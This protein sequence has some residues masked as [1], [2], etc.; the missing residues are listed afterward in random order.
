MLRFNPVDL[1]PASR[2]TGDWAQLRTRMMPEVDSPAED[3]DVPPLAHLS[4]SPTSNADNDRDSCISHSSPSGSPSS[5]VDLSHN[6][7]QQQPQQPHQHPPA[8]PFAAPLP[9][10]LSPSVAN[11]RPSGSVATTVADAS[12]ML[13]MINQLPVPP[14]S[15][16]MVH[17]HRQHYPTTNHLHHQH[18]HH[19]HLHYNTNTQLTTHHQPT[20][21][22]RHHPYATIGDATHE[23]L[24]RVPVTTGHITVQ[25]QSLHCEPAAAAADAL[26]CAQPDGTAVGQ[27]LSWHPHV[28]AK[29]PRSP[30]PHSIVDILGGDRSAQATATAAAMSDARATDATDATDDRP[31]HQQDCA[32]GSINAILNAS[33]VHAKKTR[34]EREF[35]R[36]YGHQPSDGLL[37]ALSPGPPLLGN[38]QPLNLCIAK[39]PDRHT[40]AE[41]PPPTALRKGEN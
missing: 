31:A 39:A 32:D 6:H 5:S 13:N 4:F 24:L 27:V 34:V 21:T 8:G 29:C 7:Y 30:T 41:G 36:V 1:S 19:N 26:R 14:L 3:V 28:Y 10:P 20:A 2:G 23:H 11:H 40:G 16:Q 22:H 35:C 37:S 12:D 38:D 17:D 25:L 33:R 9:P 18:N 15:S